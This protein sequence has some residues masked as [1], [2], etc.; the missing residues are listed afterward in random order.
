MAPKACDIEMTC[1]LVQVI[2]A[3]LRISTQYCLLNWPCS[4]SLV[5]IH[6]LVDEVW[7]THVMLVSA[8]EH[9][10]NGGGSKCTCDDYMDALRASCMN[11][12]S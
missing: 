3:S 5:V 8:V 1:D 9:M 7:K 12:S 6:F 11:A 10:Q 4:Q 2:F